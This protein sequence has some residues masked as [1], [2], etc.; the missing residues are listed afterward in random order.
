MGPYNLRGDCACANGFPVLAEGLYVVI[1]QTTAPN[2]NLSFFFLEWEGGF[3]KNLVGFVS[4]VCIQ[5][6]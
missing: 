3:L 5:S 6:C 1:I 4:G 2:G